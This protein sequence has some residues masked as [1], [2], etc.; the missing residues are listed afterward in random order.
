MTCL[1]DRTQGKKYIIFLLL[2]L[3]YNNIFIW[4]ILIHKKEN[5]VVIIIINLYILEDKIKWN[6]FCEEKLEI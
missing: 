5:V 6:K 3:N 4:I 2:E 1:T